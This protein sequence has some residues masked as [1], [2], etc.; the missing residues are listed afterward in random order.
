VRSGGY[1]DLRRHLGLRVQ[2]PAAPTYVPVLTLFA[3]AVLMALAAS[4]AALGIPWTLQAA[5]WAGAFA[6]CLPAFLKMQDLGRFATIFL[7]YD[8][9]AR[10]WVPYARL[11]PFLDSRAA[12][13]C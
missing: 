6:M 7:G 8:L 2:D 4:Q 12:P 9:L 10:R 13:A 1:E 3:T 5:E 11:Y